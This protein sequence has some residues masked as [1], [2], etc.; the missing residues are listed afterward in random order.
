[1]LHNINQFPVLDPGEQPPLPKMLS[2]K[3]Y[4]HPTSQ[5]YDSRIGGWTDIGANSSIVQSSVDDY[6]YTAGDNP[7]N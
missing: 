1:M 3:P 7:I 4:I 5:I 2:N 6:T